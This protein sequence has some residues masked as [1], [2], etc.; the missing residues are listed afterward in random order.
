MGWAI[1]MGHRVS[2]MVLGVWWNAWEVLL[3]GSL[4]WLSVSVACLSRQWQHRAIHSESRLATMWG[5]D[6]P[7]RGSLST[8]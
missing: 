7:Y 2:R 6:Q 8:H 3:G 5:V 1:G 4:R